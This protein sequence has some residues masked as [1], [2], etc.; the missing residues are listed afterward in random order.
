MI[1]DKSGIADAKNFGIQATIALSF[2]GFHAL[3]LVS[4]N[5][6][7]QQ[8]I[9]AG[10]FVFLEAILGGRLLQSVFRFFQPKVTFSFIPVSILVLLTGL[11]SGSFY[12]L[13]KFLPSE[14]KPLIYAPNFWVHLSFLFLVYWLM[15]YE[16]WFIKN[17]ARMAKETQR[18]LEIQNHLK[19]AEIKNLQQN[20]Q[21]HFLFNSLNSIS[22]LTLIDP[23]QAQQMIVQLSDFLRHSVL[24]NQ[25]KYVS[26]KE[27]LE[28]IRRYLSIEQIRFSHRLNFN[29]T[30]ETMNDEVQIP[31]MIL[32][33]LVEN[34]VKHGLLADTS[35]VNIEM[36][37]ERRDH[38]LWIYLSNPIDQEE[39]TKKGTGF[40][41]SSIRKKLYLLYA[42]NSL[43]SVRADNGRFET[44]LKI[45]INNEGNTDR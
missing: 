17:K 37:S 42:E 19:D 22:S 10:S 39:K 1:L 31:F 30:H 23:A 32:Q 5:V 15:Y 20:F 13:I 24:K 21:P 16:W 9:Y 8:A 36:K 27:E 14:W 33:P 41:L 40:G 26:L 4:S 29:L 11:I 38:Y 35:E 2:G 34:A 12:L 45:P 43:L 44:I 7:V 3:G 6:S 18:L 25:R 28:Q